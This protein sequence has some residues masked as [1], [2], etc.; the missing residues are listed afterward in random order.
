MKE[1]EALDGSI[2]RNV[3]LVAPISIDNEDMKEKEGVDLLYLEESY[4]VFHHKEYVFKGLPI[5]SNEFTPLIV[6]IPH[7]RS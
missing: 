2:E 7:L 1:N 6:L 3:L 4:S 5:E